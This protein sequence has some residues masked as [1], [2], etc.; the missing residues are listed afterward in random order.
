MASFFP[1]L[2]SISLAGAGGAL[3]VM[4][5]RLFLKKAPR[6]CTLLL[7]AFVA[8]RLLCPFT[9]ELPFALAP[10]PWAPS[11]REEAIAQPSPFSPENINGIPDVTFDV[12]SATENP[13]K[14]APSPMTAA[15]FL[16]LAGLGV[17][18]GYTLFSF[19][20]L[21]RKL[22]ESVIWKDN[23]W[24][25]DHLPSPFL[26]GLFRPKIYLPSSL[27]T[28][29][30]PYVV[31]HEQTHLKQLDHV[32]KLLAFLILA[33][34]WFNPVLWF[35]Y[36]LFCRD[37]EFF[38]DQRVLDKLGTEHKK[39]YCQALI[40][41]SVPGKFTAP[42]A[43]AFGESS[44]KSRIRQALHYQK[45]A[46]RWAF[47]GATAC[48]LAAL[49]L[50]TAP[51]DAQNPEDSATLSHSGEQYVF[52]SSQDTARLTL[53]PDTK[54]FTFSP[55]FLSSAL[56]TGRYQEQGDA[57]TL[58][59]TQGKRYRFLRQQGGFVFQAEGSDPMP[60]FRYSPGAALSSAVPD[61]SLF[62][63]ETWTPYMDQALLDVDGDG[64]KEAC[65]LC[66]G[67]TSGVFTFALAAL[68]EDKVEYFNIYSCN[69]ATFSF[70]E[71]RE[72]PTVQAISQNGSVAF[73]TIATQGDDLLLM[74]GDQS[75]PLWGDAQDQGVD[76]PHL[77][78]C[79][80]R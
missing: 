75:L 31:A 80:R 52:S 34:H 78:Y 73:F 40:R 51:K 9:L 67:P 53:F 15:F 56:Y 28:Q 46:V 5:L 11:E 1:Q 13:E 42:C 18:A 60:E 63:P 3:V 79:I 35:A 39:G 8:L 48:L 49:C 62:V 32:W 37:L 66:Y 16:W 70:A 44:L 55:S 22:G 50:F 20:A 36:L 54:E 76:S 43:L 6:W 74:Q 26:L 72:T 77:S 30:I 47:L 2:L 41:C 27:S 59:S 24:L 19:L 65:Y 61:G 12:P 10:S 45:P 7:W 69:F 71:N 17:M 68:E 33:V 14:N 21:R 38:C 64:T 29:D 58:E 57:I 25:C 4:V 23:I